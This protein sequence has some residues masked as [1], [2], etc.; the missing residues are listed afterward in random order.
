MIPKRHNL[1]SLIFIVNCM[2][3]CSLSKHCR[4]VFNCYEV[5]SLVMQQ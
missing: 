1:I 2:S 5:V 4:N 3:K